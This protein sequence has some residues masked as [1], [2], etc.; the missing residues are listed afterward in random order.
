MKPILCDLDRTVV[1]FSALALQHGQKYHQN[2]TP[3]HRTTESSAGGIGSFHPSLQHGQA[4]RT[5]GRP[6]TSGQNEDETG[7]RELICRLMR[8]RLYGASIQK[9][10]AG[11]GKGVLWASSQ[12]HTVAQRDGVLQARQMNEP[13]T[14]RRQE[15]ASFQ[16]SLGNLSPWC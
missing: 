16:S 9:G 11:S 2:D 5:W 12:D 14:G 7:P 15:T 1:S 13:Q 8:G 4:A 3:F 6:E 10:H